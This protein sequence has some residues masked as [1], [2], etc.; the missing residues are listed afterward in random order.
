MDVLLIAVV[1]QV[2]HWKQVLLP[3]LQDA[4][5]TRARVYTRGALAF[6]HLLSNQQVQQTAVHPEGQSQVNEGAGRRPSLPIPL[7]S[8]V[9]PVPMRYRPFHVQPPMI[10]TSAPIVTQPTTA[11]SAMI[12][13]IAL[14]HGT[15]FRCVCSLYADIRNLIV[16]CMIWSLIEDLPFLF[17]RAGRGFP[18]LNPLLR[19]NVVAAVITVCQERDAAAVQNRTV[20][21][22]H[23]SH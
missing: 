20:G 21:Q 18:N 14:S 17:V 11:P 16:S 7:M 9:I 13:S 4:H 10:T 3:E 5:S 8:L 12:D 2:P 15:G 1:S 6:P 23:K 19:G 22:H